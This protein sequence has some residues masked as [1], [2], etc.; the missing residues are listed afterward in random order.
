MLRAKQFVNMFKQPEEIKTEE[1]VKKF[2]NI[3]KSSY[4]KNKNAL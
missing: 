4:G 1:N 2:V 3:F